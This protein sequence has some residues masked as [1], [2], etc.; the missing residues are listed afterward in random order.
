[1][2]PSDLPIQETDVRTITTRGGPIAALFTIILTA[3]ACGGAPA[4]PASGSPDAAPAG[5]T[6][7][8]EY[9]QMFEVGKIDIAQPDVTMAGGLT[10]LKRI[11]SLAK[12]RDRRVVPH[13]YKSNITIACSRSTG[14]KAETTTGRP[15]SSG[16]K[17]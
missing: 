17:R 9:K 16:M 4:A 2:R 10:E 6:T 7:R 14:S 8:F 5:L 15:Y 3:A 13:G 1:M 11:A 12:Q